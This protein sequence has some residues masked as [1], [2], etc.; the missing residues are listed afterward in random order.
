MAR[1]RLHRLGGQPRRRAD[2]G[3]PT[4][5]NDAG[6]RRLTMMNERRRRG[7]IA[8]LDRLKA[9]PD[10]V[11]FAFGGSGAGPLAAKAAISVP[12]ERVP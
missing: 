9:F 8:V 7:V 12:K 4:A 1:E 3:I 2:P 5:G 11:T 6:K 10:A